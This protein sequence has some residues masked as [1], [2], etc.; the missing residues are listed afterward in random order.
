MK[1]LEHRGQTRS[2]PTK[3]TQAVLKN[4]EEREREQRRMNGWEHI[5][6][7]NKLIYGG[8]SKHTYTYTTVN[9]SRVHCHIKYGLPLCKPSLNH[10]KIKPG[11][12]MTT[13]LDA[14]LF[15]EGDICL[16]GLI[17]GSFSFIFSKSSILFFIFESHILLLLKRKCW[18]W[19]GCLIT[20][21][22]SYFKH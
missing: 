2:W 5:Q 7:L 18:F 22:Y 20:M 13:Q 11:C 8:S 6:Y 4:L 15:Y 9:H 3:Q 10:L 14:L 16:P 21:K 12:D 1:R 17:M 19:L